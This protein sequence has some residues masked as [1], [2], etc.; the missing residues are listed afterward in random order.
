MKVTGEHIKVLLEV[1][2]TRT[3]RSELERYGLNPHAK[4]VKTDKLIDKLTEE[5][6]DENFVTY[7]G[8]SPGSEK[9]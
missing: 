1:D 9:L 2:D 6:E 7:A 3:V 8:Q 4:F 5:K